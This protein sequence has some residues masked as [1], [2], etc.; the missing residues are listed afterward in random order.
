MTYRS[1]YSDQRLEQ[2]ANDIRAVTQ[3]GSDTWCMF[4]NTASSAA[5]SNALSLLAKL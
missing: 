1:C 3:Q 5:L 2:Y 4:D